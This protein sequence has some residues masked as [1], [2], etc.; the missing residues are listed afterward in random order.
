[1]SMHARVLCS[2]IARA[3]DRRLVAHFS[4]RATRV[5]YRL[6]VF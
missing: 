5:L 6:H 2:P 1:M 3:D 4:V